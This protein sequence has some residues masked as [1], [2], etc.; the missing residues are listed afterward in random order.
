[1]STRG[2]GGEA[3][4]IEGGANVEG[5]CGG[6]FGGCGEFGGGSG[7]GSGIRAVSMKALAAT[8]VT[9]GGNQMDAND[10]H[11]ANARVPMVL[12]EDGS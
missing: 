2:L 3:A 1:M 6:A 7:G 9:F 11:P 10:E 4:S 8:V 5:G 12:T